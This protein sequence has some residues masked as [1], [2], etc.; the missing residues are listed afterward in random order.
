MRFYMVDRILEVQKDV[1]IKGLK[2]VS[3]VEDFF[4]GQ[5]SEDEP[6]LPM[7]L[8]IEALAQL[9]AWFVAATSD[10]EKRAVLLSLGELRFHRPARPGDQ[11]LLEDWVVSASDDNAVVSGRIRVGDEIIMEMDECMCAIIPTGNLEDPAQM[12][13]TYEWLTGGAAR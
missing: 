11:L 4:S 10:F 2:N 5:S 6:E 8:L 12:R 1:S 13:L 9:G 3:I 7:P